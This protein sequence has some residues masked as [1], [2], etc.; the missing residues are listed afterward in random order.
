[1]RGTPAARGAGPQGPV[2]GVGDFE[3]A[4]AVGA[5]N[6]VGSLAV[7]AAN[8]CVELEAVRVGVTLEEEGQGG[9]GRVA[10]GRRALD[11]GRLAVARRQHAARAADLDALVVAEHRAARV[12]DLRDAAASGAQRHRRRVDVARGADRGVD[13]AAAVRRDL[14][15]LLAEQPACH[16]EVVDRHVAEHAS[17]AQHVLRPA[18]A[19]GRG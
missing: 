8:E 7:Q 17:R 10:G 19:T 4:H 5:R 14:D 1:M 6:D 3:G 9:V 2:A 11:R 12:R 18:A 15:R 13:Q 16:V